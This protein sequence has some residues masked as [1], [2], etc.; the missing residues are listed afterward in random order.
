[1]KAFAGPQPRLKHHRGYS[2]AHKLD[3]QQ[4]SAAWVLQHGVRHPGLQGP[5][6][7]LDAAALQE[8]AAADEDH[9]CGGQAQLHPPG[10]PVAAGLRGVAVRYFTHCERRW[11][12]N[13]FQLL[14][15]LSAV[16]SA[17]P[18]APILC[19]QQYATLPSLFVAVLPVAPEHSRRRSRVAMQSI[20]PALL[21]PP[22]LIKPAAPAP[23]ALPPGPG[24]T[25][26]LRQAKLHCE[27]ERGWAAPAQRHT[28]GRT[29]GTA[30]QLLCRAVRAVRCRVREGL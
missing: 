28:T 19:T 17:W 30:R 25:A 12:K 24:S 15:Q 10:A 20:P 2:A 1:M 3:Y 29:G 16:P 7:H 18:G 8:A 22:F 5:K 21:H 4:V 26:A 27:P 6:W 14:F 23:A 13:S 11:H 9:L